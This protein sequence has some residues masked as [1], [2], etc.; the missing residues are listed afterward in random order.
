M[1]TWQQR[2]PGAHHDENNI[3][4]FFGNYRWLSNFEP[5]FVEYEGLVYPS[6]EAAYQ[7]A[8][9]VNPAERL[10]FVDISASAAKQ[11][12]KKVMIRKDWEKVKLKV[13]EDVLISK[14]TKNSYLRDKLMATAHKH[15]EETN[16]WNDRFWGVYRGEGE[17]HLGKLLMKVRT[18]LWV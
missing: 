4:G 13:M 1:T 5:C 12:G 17:N 18:F 15:L 6:S 10:W 9:C 8:K 11:L 14:F 2:T 16:W 7:A 3:L